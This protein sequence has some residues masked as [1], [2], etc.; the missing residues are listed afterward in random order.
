[1]AH[2]PGRTLQSSQSNIRNLQKQL[3]DQSEMILHEGF[4]WQNY[5]KRN[6]CSPLTATMAK[7]FSTNEASQVQAP[8]WNPF[9]CDRFHS[10]S[11]TLNTKKYSAKVI[12]TLLW[13]SF[14]FD[15]A[16]QGTLMPW[17][18]RF[19]K[20]NF[21]FMQSTWRVATGLVSVRRSP[22]AQRS[23]CS[24]RSSSDRI[25]KSSVMLL[26]YWGGLCKESPLPA[27]QLKLRAAL[28]RFWK[29]LEAMLTAAWHLN[30]WHTHIP[31]SLT[32]HQLFTSL[33]G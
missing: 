1:M 24:G 8:T 2:S 25:S 27:L 10:S 13:D 5:K 9:R 4:Y 17:L 19:K 21:P 3:F 12:S 33:K 18:T 20:Q 7:H 22:C 32:I 28:F 11:F 26:P 31:G 29:C 15:K 14:K 23:P 6:S 30:L 16:H